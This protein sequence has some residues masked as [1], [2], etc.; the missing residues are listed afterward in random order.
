MSSG[1][2][3]PVLPAPII[4]EQLREWLEEGFIEVFAERNHGN[5]N[6]REICQALHHHRAW[7]GRHRNGA[8]VADIALYLNTVS[9]EMGIYFPPPLVLMRA[10][11]RGMRWLARQRG[12]IPMAPANDDR[13]AW[14][15]LLFTYLQASASE[16]LVHLTRMSSANRLRVFDEQARAFEQWKNSLQ[17][18]PLHPRCRRPSADDLRCWF[19][20][21][22]VYW[23]ELV[24]ACGWIDNPDEGE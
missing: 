8:P 20:H 15:C 13:H 10:L 17:S 5:H 2:P 22:L 23:D 19:G 16:G 7:I 21:W 14:D 11:G 6:V 3:Q 9:F 24:Q 18:A 12:R 4:G 1:T